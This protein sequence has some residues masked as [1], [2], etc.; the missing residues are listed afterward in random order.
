MAASIDDVEAGHWHEDVLN[1]RKTR[2]ERKWGKHEKE[3]RASF[4]PSEVSDVT[5]ERNTFVSCASLQIHNCNYS[6]VFECLQ[7]FTLHTAMLTPRMALAPNLFL[8]SV[9]SRDN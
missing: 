4:Y 5:V 2:H 6:H 9:P 7:C 3:G 1:L 8:L